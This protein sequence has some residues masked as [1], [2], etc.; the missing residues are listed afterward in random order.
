MIF[1]I[2]IKKCFIKHVCV[3]LEHECMVDY[4][5]YTWNKCIDENTMYGC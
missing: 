5:R 4:I 1:L 2:I 3:V